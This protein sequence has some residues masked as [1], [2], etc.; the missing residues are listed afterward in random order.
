MAANVY[1]ISL[2][3]CGMAGTNR[4]CYVIPAS[5]NVEPALLCRRLPIF[6]GLSDGLVQRDLLWLVVLSDDL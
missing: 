2:A 5:V 3:Q 1:K 4:Y 6:W